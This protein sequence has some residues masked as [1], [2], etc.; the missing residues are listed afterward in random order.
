[1]NEATV[2]VRWCCRC[3]ESQFIQPE[4][5]PQPCQCGGEFFRKDHP[6]EVDRWAHL[7]RY[8]EQFLAGLRIATR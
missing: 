6:P 4:D 2:R 7:T 3:G 8:D 5:T 1:M